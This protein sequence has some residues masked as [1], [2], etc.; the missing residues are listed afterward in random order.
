MSEYKSTASRLVRLFKQSRDKWKERSKAKQKKIRALET[1]VRDLSR[2]RDQWKEK[3][4]EARQELAALKREKPGQGKTSE[5]EERDE[6]EADQRPPKGA[7]WKQAKGHHYPVEVVQLGIE[8][9]TKS[10]NSLRGSEKTFALFRQYFE[11]PV[12]SFSSIRSWV[13]RVGLY[14]LK[15]RPVY[16]EDW[17]M[18]LDLSIELGTLKCLVILGIPVSRLAQSGYALSHQDV[19]V[20]DMVVLSSCTGA[21]I[22]AQLEKLSQALG[23]PVQIVSDDGSD[24]KK[25][26]ALYQQQHPGVIRSYD[27]THQM[28]LF[29]EKELRSDEQYQAFVSQCNLTRQRIKQTPLYFLT[30][31][32]QRPKARYLNVQEQIHWAQQ[33]LHYQAQADF[34]AITPHFGL[35]KRA[36][37]QLQELVDPETLSCLSQLKPKIYPDRSSFAEHLREGVD[38]GLAAQ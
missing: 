2:S 38:A 11:V 30:P 24:V 16:D 8:Q 33:V 5:L 37:A 35:D 26:V 27:V 25:G 29:L 21:V 12:P 20:L 31:P 36:L 34:S 4:K 14:E 19:D 18:M 17:M 15:N 32:K 9:V 1:Q 3:A 6:E 23:P 7:G 13:L 10:L 22:A 28:A